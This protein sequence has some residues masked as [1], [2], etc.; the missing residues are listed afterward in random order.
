[1]LIAPCPSKLISEARRRLGLT[2][3]ETSRRCQFSRSRLSD[4]ERGYRMPNLHEQAELSRLLKISKHS[5]NAAS[6]QGTRP[7]LKPL[8]EK[9]CRNRTFTIEKDR[10]NEVRLYA[11]KRSQPKLSRALL[12]KIL[13]RRDLGWIR[14]YLREARFDSQL[15]LLF[16]MQLLAH[17]A[18]PGWISPQIVGFD[19]FPIICPRSKRLVGHEKHPALA[20]NEI[21]LFPQLTIRTRRLVVRADIIT[22]VKRRGRVIWSNVELDGQ[23]HDP[24]QDILRE[25]E[26]GLPTLRLCPRAIGSDELFV[27]LKDLQA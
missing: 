10:P 19:T 16:S 11:L 14:V 27:R 4:L 22:G 25:I 5:L 24:H 18:R 8:R 15:E 6:P 23:G 26:L 2:Q 9:F 21:L 13:K 12:G 3:K 17:G 7:S 1:M 20:W